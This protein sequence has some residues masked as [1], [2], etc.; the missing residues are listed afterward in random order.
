MATNT[1]PKQKNQVLMLVILLLLLTAGGMFILY[2]K[3]NA[4]L[5]ISAENASILSRRVEQL[6]ARLQKT[7]VVAPQVQVPLKKSVIEDFAKSFSVSLGSTETVKYSIGS[8]EEYGDVTLVSYATG[9]KPQAIL[10]LQKREVGSTGGQ[11]ISAAVMDM[12]T[13]VGDAI[14]SGELSLKVVSF[15]PNEVVLKASVATY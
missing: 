7:N 10:K 9:T 5:S 3:M 8:A 12:A 14:T 4:D 2:L 1:S 11:T 13:K 6:E 15:G